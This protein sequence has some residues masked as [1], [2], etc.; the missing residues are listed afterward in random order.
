MIRNIAIIGLGTMG[1][2]MAARLARGGLQVVAYDVA[3]AAIERARSMLSVAETVLDALGIALPSAGVG[4]VRF[5]DDIGDAVSG[6]DLVIENVPENI[7]I[8]ADVYRTIDG[9]IGQD[10]IVASDTSGI[11]ITKLQ[12]HISYPER[13]VGMH[14]SNPPHIIP[15]IEVIAGEKTAPQTVATIR[16]LIRS[17]GLLPVVVK[18][19]VPGFVENRVLYAL[20][21]EAVDLVE[22]GVID[23]ED[24]DTC[25][26][27]G[28]GYKIAVIGPMALLDMAGLDIYKSVSSFLN[29]DLSN[30][31]DVAPMVLEKTSASKF[32]IK[33]GEGMFCY[34][35]EQTKALQAE[36]ARKLVAVRRILE[37]RE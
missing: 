1:P 5:T 24:L 7:S 27:W 17:I 6:A 32:G 36:R 26:S 19:D 13:M 29:A 35:P 4:T 15:M 33:S 28:I 3:P 21:R 20:L 37:G 16:D 2:G 14:W 34:T 25:V 31:D 23:P 10:T 11:P 8:K 18:K 12:A 9:L 30:R 22:R